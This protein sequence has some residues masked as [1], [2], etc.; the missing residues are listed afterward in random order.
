[1]HLLVSREYE[2]CWDQEED[3]DSV[4]GDVESLK[5]SHTLKNQKEGLFITVRVYCLDVK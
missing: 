1:M 2:E 5:S 3:G 4:S